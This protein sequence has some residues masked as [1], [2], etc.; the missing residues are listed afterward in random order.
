MSSK[1]L[2]NP[3]DQQYINVGEDPPLLEAIAVKNEDSPDFMKR[4][5]ILKRIRAN[6]Q[7]WHEVGLEGGDTVRKLVSSHAGSIPLLMNVIQERVGEAHFNRGEA[8]T[9]AQSRHSRY[10]L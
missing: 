4:D 9:R 5:D 1:G 2:V 6:M 7:S 3:R 8:T 10:G